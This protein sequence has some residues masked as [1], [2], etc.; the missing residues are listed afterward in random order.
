MA[1]KSPTLI[2]PALKTMLTNASILSYVKQVLLG[3][4]DNMM[5]FPTLCIEPSSDEESQAAYDKQYCTLQV[6]IFGFITS[7]DRDK[8]LVGSG[9]DKGI[10]DL[11]NDVK[12]AL[13]S[14]TTISGTANW[15]AIKTVEY[16]YVVE[17]DLR[18]FTMR[19]DIEYDQ[20]A[21]DRT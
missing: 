14:D 3:V 19:V 17:R 20:K 10:V 7:L 15:L 16:D 2:L 8:M 11:A 4:R 18:A 12:E 1:S 5:A 13:C 21:S 6:M 9:S